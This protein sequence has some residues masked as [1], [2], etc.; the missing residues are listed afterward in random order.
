MMNLVNSYPGRVAGISTLNSGQA[1]AVSLSG[2]CEQLTI[3]YIAQ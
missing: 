2:V 3:G 1:Y